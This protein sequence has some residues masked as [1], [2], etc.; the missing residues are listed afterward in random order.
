M[1]DNGGGLGAQ[2]LVF[3]FCAITEIVFDRHLAADRRQC[4]PNP[5]E[6]VGL[7]GMEQR[8]SVF[9]E[10]AEIELVERFR[11]S[12]R[13]AAFARRKLDE[14]V[15]DNLAIHPADDMRDVGR[16]RELRQPANVQDLGTAAIEIRVGNS[17]D[18]EGVRRFE[19][20]SLLLHQVPGGQAVRRPL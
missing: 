14:A 8:F 17:L 13:N 1:R 5:I 16:R 9:A 11:R 2:T 4:E 6:K 12:H 10:H 3:A 18:K 19:P 20:W 7:L 15:K